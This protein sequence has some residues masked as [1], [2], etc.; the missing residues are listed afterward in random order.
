MTLAIAL[1]LIAFTATQ[2]H[3]LAAGFSGQPVNE[4]VKECRSAINKDAR[5]FRVDTGSPDT[6]VRYSVGVGGDAPSVEFTDLLT[7]D[8]VALSAEFAGA[9]GYFCA[10]VPLSCRQNQERW[11]ERVRALGIAPPPM[12]KCPDRAK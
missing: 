1:L 7:G 4:G 11:L 12:P 2:A 9:H 3:S 8:R 10:P 6:I 5:V